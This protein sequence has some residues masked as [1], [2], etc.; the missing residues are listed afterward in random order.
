MDDWSTHLSRRLVVNE[1]A[2]DHPRTMTPTLTRPAPSWMTNLTPYQLIKA[3]TDE[4]LPSNDLSLICSR[5]AEV[6]VEKAGRVLSD[7]WCSSSA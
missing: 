3:K 7:R 4:S 6:A 1:P 5:T 2:H